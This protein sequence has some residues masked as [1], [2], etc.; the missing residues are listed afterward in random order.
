MQNEYTDQD[1]D[2]KI[3]EYLL[4]KGIEPHAWWYKF[5]DNRTPKGV[6]IK[7]DNVHFITRKEIENYYQTTIEGFKRNQI[8]GCK[9]FVPAVSFLQLLEGLPEW[10]QKD[11][12]SIFKIG[13]TVYRKDD[14]RRKYFSCCHQLINQYWGNP[15]T[16]M[17]EIYKYLNQEGLL[18]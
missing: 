14:R 5:E 9:Y 4:G 8:P 15:M 3:I 1:L 2:P 12:E 16:I 13:A 7:C 10:F 18:K 11:I 6:I 17:T